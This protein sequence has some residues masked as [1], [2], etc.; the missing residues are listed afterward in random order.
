[1]KGHLKEASTIIHKYVQPDKI[2]L[3]NLEKNMEEQEVQEPLFKATPIKL[4]PVI[5]EEQKGD[6]IASRT[7]RQ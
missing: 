6:S 4:K 1:M 2:H 3:Q 5:I 7:R